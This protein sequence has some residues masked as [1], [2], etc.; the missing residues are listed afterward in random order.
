M[1]TEAEDRDH[2]HVTLIWTWTPKLSIHVQV[3]MHA[4][5]W[6][7]DQM[8]LKKRYGGRRLFSEAH[9]HRLNSEVVL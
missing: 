7:L 4:T 2:H 8:D 1:E 9:L 5:V 3:L 6:H